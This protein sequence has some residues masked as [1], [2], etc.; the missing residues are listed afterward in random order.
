[1][2]WH[3]RNTLDEPLFTVAPVNRDLP[4]RNAFYDLAPWKFDPEPLRHLLPERAIFSNKAKIG[5]FLNSDGL[6]VV[7]DRFKTVLEGLEPD[8]HQF[9]PIEVW[10][11]DGRQEEGTWWMFFAGQVCIAAMGRRSG[12]DGNWH[13]R[14]GAPYTAFDFSQHP[15]LNARRIGNRHLWWNSIQLKRMKF[16][17]SDALMAGWVE[18]GLDLRHMIRRPAEAVDEPYDTEAELGEWLR[19]Y[20]AHPENLRASANREL[21][22]AAKSE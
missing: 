3:I 10:R 5:D 21:Y 20:E 12:W 22:D 4:F 17:C 8:I 16:F 11:K 18:A 1:M 13:Y 7:S 19:Y 9:L 6:T 14:G 15:V 2:P